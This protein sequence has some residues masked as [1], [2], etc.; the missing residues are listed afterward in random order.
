MYIYIYI[1]I[2]SYIKLENITDNEESEHYEEYYVNEWHRQQ[3]KERD[4]LHTAEQDSS[5]EECA[6]LRYQTSGEFINGGIPVVSNNDVETT[7]D[8]LPHP[9]DDRGEGTNQKDRQ[10]RT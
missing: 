1:C 3:E 6:R 7:T 4:P 8:T 10:D 9:C 2:Y 5:E